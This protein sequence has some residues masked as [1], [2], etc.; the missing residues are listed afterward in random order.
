MAKK[1][2][3]RAL[4]G[5]IAQ[6]AKQTWHG[7]R[8]YRSN[9][10]VGLDAKLDP[11]MAWVG[12]NW[13]YLAAGNPMLEY[14]NDHTDDHRG[15]A[16]L[17]AYAGLTAGF[18]WGNKKLG[19]LLTRWS[20]HKEAQYR[21]GEQATAA[22]WVKTIAAP[23]ALT[24]AL[25][26]NQFATA[27]HN[28][29]SDGERVVHSFARTPIEAPKPETV[30]TQEDVLPEYPKKVDGI[31]DTGAL[32]GRNLGDLYALYTGISGRV[33]QKVSGIDFSVQLEKMFARKVSWMRRHKKSNPVVQQ[34][35][36]ERFPVYASNKPT[37]M[38]LDTYLD[39]VGRSMDDVKQNIDC[40][41]IGELY[42]LSKE[43]TDLVC[44]MGMSLTKNDVVAY[45]LTE[46]MPAA[47]GELN[48]AVLDHMLRNGGQEYV[49]NIPAQSDAKT[50]F[51]LYQFTEFALYNANGEVR[52]ASKANLALPQ[53]K[54]I[55]GSMI[56]LKGED[57][58]KAAYLFAWHNLARLAQNLDRAEFNTLATKWADKKVDIVEYIAT[59]HHAPGGYTSRHGYIGAIGAA[60]RWLDNDAKLEF[61]VSCKGDLPWYAQKTKANMKALYR[62]N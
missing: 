29:K 41:K 61:S 13:A 35:H 10:K 28:Y 32:A 3:V 1:V 22:S 7:V 25:F 47:D 33:P 62:R 14:V 8:A 9:F 27:L 59:A 44:A 11:A 30:Q 21:A 2:G 40:N 48:K 17:G 16:M 49:D 36:D 43:K 57:H 56:F 18:V 51:G 4:P 60:K 12:A 26:S 54:R 34:Y 6:G 39:I 24:A 38:T 50:S 20:D 53:G 31:V 23:I 46:L 15:L 19:Q 37:L 5:I 52:G 42:K 58:H 55:P 45:G